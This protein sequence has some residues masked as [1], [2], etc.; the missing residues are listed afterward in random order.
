VAGS[1]ALLDAPPKVQITA[2]TEVDLLTYRKSQIAIHH[3]SD[4]TVVAVIEIVCP[5]NKASRHALRTFVEKALELMSHGTHLLVIDLFPP[6]P[7]DPQGIH[8]AIWSEIEETDFKLPPEKPLTLASY[9]AG[10][11]KRAFIQPVGAEL[12]DMPL[13]LEPGRYVEVPLAA[14]YRAAWDG[15]PAFWRD[16]LEKPK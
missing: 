16:Q 5:G 10:T 12:P 1:V 11:L 4:H 3:S 7:R 8:G 2:T 14:T 15:V 9:S 13:F 6:G